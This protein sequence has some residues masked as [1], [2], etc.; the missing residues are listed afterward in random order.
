MRLQ[1]ILFRPK[2]VVQE[3]D[4][5]KRKLAHRKGKAIEAPH[6]ARLQP[7]LKTKVQPPP[8]LLFNP[9]VDLLLFAL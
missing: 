6:A 3:N 4:F 1:P 2:E 8:G 9:P 5:V 7:I